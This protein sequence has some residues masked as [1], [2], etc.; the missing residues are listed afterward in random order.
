[1]LSVLCVYPELCMSRAVLWGDG[2]C[3]GVCAG[4]GK[5][6]DVPDVH[7]AVRQGWREKEVLVME[8]RVT[9]SVMLHSATFCL[10][11][12]KKYR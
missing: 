1:M 7:S 12:S 5:Q 6:A 10:S 3:R 4:Q 8:H 11:P 9:T 2:W